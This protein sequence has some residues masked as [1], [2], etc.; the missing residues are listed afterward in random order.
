M[1]T[2]ITHKNPH[3]DEIMCIWMIKRFLSGWSSSA[4]KYVA[5][6]PKG[7]SV[8]GSDADANKMYIG[9]GRGKFDEHKGNIED[10]ATTLVY[11]FLTREKKIALSKLDAAALRELVSYINDEDHGR[12][13]TQPLAEYTM[14]STNAFLPRAGYSS[15]EILNFG[16]VYFDGVFECLIE[17]AQLEKDWVG[18]KIVKTISGP[19]V[20]LQTTVNAKSVLRRA[21]GE[22][23]QIAIIVNPKNKFRS[24]RAVPESSVDLTESFE[25]AKA[26]EPKAEW[27]LH[28]SKKMLICGS[29][30][31]ENKSLSKLNLEKMCGLI[32]L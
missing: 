27:Y 16:M 26:L 12:H 10:S 29:D 19:A 3:L 20:A 21:V 4:V 9:V 17:K 7:G 11:A 32:A 14:G 28:H 22:G 5:T 13:I 2:I 1:K 24:I 30:V 31:A 23:I 15:A 25:R 18:K 6:N 8:K